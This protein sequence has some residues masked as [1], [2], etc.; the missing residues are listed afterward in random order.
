MT[1]FIC[2]RPSALKTYD[3]DEDGNFQCT[4]VRASGEEGYIYVRKNHVFQ[5]WS[6][7]V[8]SKINKVDFESKCAKFDVVYEEESFLIANE[9]EEHRE[10]ACMYLSSVLGLI[11][12][13]SSKRDMILIEPFLQCLVDFIG[14][15]QQKPYFLQ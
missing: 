5:L 12:N 1:D 8:N 7:R 9:R 13:G 10:T 15:F 3:V 2:I 4:F 14:K 6:G 11:M